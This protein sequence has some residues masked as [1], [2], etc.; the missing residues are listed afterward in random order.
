LFRPTSRGSL[1]MGLRPRRV[2]DAR[3][4]KDTG[5]EQRG[6]EAL[7]RRASDPAECLTRDAPEPREQKDFDCDIRVRSLLL[8][9]LSIIHPLEAWKKSSLT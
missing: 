1:T 9:R 7:L 4:A 5:D 3:R 8:T 6:R 2:S